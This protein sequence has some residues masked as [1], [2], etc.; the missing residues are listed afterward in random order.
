VTVKVNVEEVIV[1]A[2]MGWVNCTF[3]EL[4]AAIL[5]ALLAGE[6]K[7]TAGTGAAA[8]VNVHE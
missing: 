7:P 3:K 4:E 2:F 6:V 8:V 1:L 5:T